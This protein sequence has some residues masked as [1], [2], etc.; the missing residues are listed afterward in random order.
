MNSTTELG[1]MIAALLFNNSDMVTVDHVWIHW[2]VGASWL[3]FHTVF[4]VSSEENSFLASEDVIHSVVDHSWLRIMI[5]LFHSHGF[6]MVNPMMT[7]Y[8]K[9]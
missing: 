7:Q 1:K 2:P 4:F 5:I 8:C 3:T 6:N 9:W